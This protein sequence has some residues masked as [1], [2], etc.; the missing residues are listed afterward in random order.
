[1]KSS[2]HWSSALGMGDGAPK[3]DMPRE[4]VWRSS[5]PEMNYNMV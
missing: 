5:L 2:S 4:L 1:M 3:D